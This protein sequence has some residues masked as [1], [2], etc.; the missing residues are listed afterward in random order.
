LFWNCFTYEQ[1]RSQTIEHYPSF[2]VLVWFSEPCQ[3]MFCV[4]NWGYKPSVS[5]LG[6]L[7]LC[8]ITVISSHLPYCYG[9]LFIQSISLVIFINSYLPFYLCKWTPN[10]ACYTCYRFHRVSATCLRPFHWKNCYELH[11]PCFTTFFFP[12][13]VTEFHY[14]S[15]EITE[16]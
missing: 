3:C 6:H 9:Q 12:R 11:F 5:P 2:P 14:Q 15:K 7:L 1:C 8:D 16:F 13:P 10:L 4:G